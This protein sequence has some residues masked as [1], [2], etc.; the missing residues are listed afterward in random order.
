MK[1]EKTVWD[2]LHEQCKPDGKG[3]FRTVDV[4]KIAK[5]IDAERLLLKEENQILKSYLKSKGKL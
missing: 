1:K 4:I 3:R 2:R 5:E